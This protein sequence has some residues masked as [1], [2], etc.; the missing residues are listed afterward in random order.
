LL[1]T[2]TAEYNKLSIE[3]DKGLSVMAGLDPR[4][5]MSDVQM[6]RM[7]AASTGATLTA[8]QVEELDARSSKRQ[9]AGFQR[10]HKAPGKPGLGAKPKA[11]KV[12]QVTQ[13]RVGPTGARTGREKKIV[14]PSGVAEAMAGHIKGSMGRK[15]VK[16]SA[17][18][19]GVPSTITPPKGN[20][21]TSDKKRKKG[22]IL[23]QGR[24]FKFV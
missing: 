1:R 6:K 21:F 14:G 22:G 10:K 4:T 8:G 12:K 11:P 7:L 20:G 5:G 23:I 2:I 24:T 18:A 3:W 19:S 16:S 9:G 15:G 13:R 17:V